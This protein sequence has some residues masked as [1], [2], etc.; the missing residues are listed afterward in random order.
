MAPP[1][2]KDEALSRY[3]A[4]GE[5]PRTKIGRLRGDDEEEED[6]EI[7]TLGSGARH[8]LEVGSLL[9][10]VGNPPDKDSLSP[11]LAGLGIERRCSHEGKSPSLST[12]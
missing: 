12:T 6:G 11:R 10:P 9:I 8:C 3:S 1:S 5:V 4:S 7:P 2:W